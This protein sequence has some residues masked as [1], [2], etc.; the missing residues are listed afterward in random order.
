MI[1]DSCP[2]GIKLITS[3][4][5]FYASDFFVLIEIP[6]HA[7]ERSSA[8]NNSVSLH[9]LSKKMRWVVSLSNKG[10]AYTSGKS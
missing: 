3:R 9:A 6:F 5:R 4:H 2:S 8:V 10:K 7:M 1:P